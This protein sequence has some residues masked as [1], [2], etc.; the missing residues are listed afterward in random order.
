MD[1]HLVYQLRDG[2]RWGIDVQ[3]DS[4]AGT[5]NTA[6]AALPPGAII[7]DIELPMAA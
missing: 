3:A 6:L 5:I 1:Y 4:D 2:S 7:D